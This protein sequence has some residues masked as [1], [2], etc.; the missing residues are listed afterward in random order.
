MITLYA[1]PSRVIQLPDEGVGAPPLAVPHH[2]QALA[3]VSKL[4][5]CQEPAQLLAAAR[6]L[7]AVNVKVGGGGGQQGLGMAISIMVRGGRGE[8][9]G[10]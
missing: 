8:W 7:V 10:F 9:L 3:V 2:G 5:K 6:E 4:A 1:S